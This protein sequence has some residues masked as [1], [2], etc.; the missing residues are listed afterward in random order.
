MFR[1]K[2]LSILWKNSFNQCQSEFDMEL[3]LKAFHVTII[4]LLKKYFRNNFRGGSPMM[5]TNF[6]LSRPLTTKFMNNDVS[7]HCAVEAHT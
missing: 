4:D 6:S 7:R 5:Q 1:L 3:I 2:F